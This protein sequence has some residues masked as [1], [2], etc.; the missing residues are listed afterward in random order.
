[1]LYVECTPRALLAERSSSRC[2]K[3][4]FLFVFIIHVAWSEKLKRTPLGG[5]FGC[6]FFPLSLLSGIA[7]TTSV[8]LGS[9]QSPPDGVTAHFLILYNFVDKGRE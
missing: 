6:P 9:D 2:E 3:V 8:S 5:K 7:T 1:M 4:A